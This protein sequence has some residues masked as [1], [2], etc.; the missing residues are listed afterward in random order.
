MDII[1]IR[2]DESSAGSPELVWTEDTD[3]KQLIKVGAKVAGID[4][5]CKLKRLGTCYALV[6]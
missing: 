4:T 1:D 3:Y 2:A 6:T 5:S